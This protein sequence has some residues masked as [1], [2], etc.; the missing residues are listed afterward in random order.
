MFIFVRLNT[1]IA[2][3]C[4]SCGYRHSV[5]SKMVTERREFKCRRERCN[6]VWDLCPTEEK[7]DEIRKDL[8]ELHRCAKNLKEIA[9]RVGT[10]GYENDVSINLDS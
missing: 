8:S 4:P 3:D 9:E 1:Y 7:A 6:Q 10:Y 5:V 2:V